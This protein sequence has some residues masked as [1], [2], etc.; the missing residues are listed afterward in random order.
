[1]KSN[2]NALL[3]SAYHVNWGHRLNSSVATSCQF[4]YQT[5][6]MDFGVIQN[7]LRASLYLRFRQPMCLMKLRWNEGLFSGDRRENVL[8][9]WPS[10]FYPIEPDYQSHV[11]LQEWVNESNGDILISGRLA[12]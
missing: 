10:I 1:M 3:V 7:L 8:L 11:N 2:E 6:F 5:S 4:S 12:A 9:N